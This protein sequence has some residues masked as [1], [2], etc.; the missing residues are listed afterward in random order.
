MRFS[1]ISKEKKAAP[2]PPAKADAVDAPPPERG[3]EVPLAKKLKRRGVSFTVLAEQAGEPTLPTVEG[4]VPPPAQSIEHPAPAKSAPQPKPTNYR[5]PP[6]FPS[7]VAPMT[8]IAA[9][10]F[11]ISPSSPLVAKD[12]PLPRASEPAPAPAPTSLSSVPSLDPPI[13]IPT[14]RF[15]AA[16]DRKELQAQRQRAHR[17]YG[18]AISTVKSLLKNI[19]NKPIRMRDELE[20]ASNAILAEVKLK[21]HVLL[22]LTARS[23]ASNYLYAHTVNVTVMALQIGYGLKWSD[24]QL[25]ALGLIALVHDVGMIKYLHMAQEPRKLT[26]EEHE[27]LRQV[28]IQSDK[29][30]RHIQDIE[31]TMRQTISDVLTLEY[32]RK[33]GKGYPKVLNKPEEFRIAAQIIGICDVYESLTHHRTWREALLPHETMKSLVKQQ[34]KDF[35][36]RLTKTF[37]EQLSLFPPGSYVELSGGDVGSVIQVHP[38]MP[39]RPVIELKLKADGT[40]PEVSQLLDLA[41]NP[42]IHITR[43]VDETKLAVK[44]KKLLLQLQAQ[45]WWTE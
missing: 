40:Q 29:L 32:E 12:T 33:T 37:L 25:L 22:A 36:P 31:E 7:P 5:A 1:D 15:S 26:P 43:A 19:E 44:D 41:D 17:V 3:R 13:V 2:P 11:S 9:Q 24:E 4:V 27:Q 42:L 20:G 23:T 38:E 30:L 34:A 10:G 6:I 16:I 28:P 39:T 21:N 35:H 18:D 45:R 8:S 14:R